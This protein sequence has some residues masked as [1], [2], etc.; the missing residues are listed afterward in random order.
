MSDL[1]TNNTV[2]VFPNEK[3]TNGYPA[4]CD[5]DPDKTAQVIA[6]DSVNNW[7]LYVTEH[8]GDERFW[9]HY[10]GPTSAMYQNVVEDMSK[11]IEAYFA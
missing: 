4:F 11:A 1:Y 7:A 10:L 9:M 2:D 6:A 5:G 3:D 8:K